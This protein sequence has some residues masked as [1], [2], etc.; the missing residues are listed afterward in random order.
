MIVVVR[1]GEQY[2][3]GQL[4]WE[5]DQIPI[6][7]TTRRLLDLMGFPPGPRN[8]GNAVLPITYK[9]LKYENKDLI[10]IRNRTQTK[11]F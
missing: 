4:M 2:N 3:M 8:P 10:R 11:Y 1:L 6:F 7:R 9:D 5:D